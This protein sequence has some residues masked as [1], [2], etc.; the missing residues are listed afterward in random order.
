MTIA[1]FLARLQR[2]RR[3]D[4]P[5]VLIDLDVFRPDGSRAVRLI[6]V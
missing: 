5:R 1:G 3:Q 6:W 4:A 2:A